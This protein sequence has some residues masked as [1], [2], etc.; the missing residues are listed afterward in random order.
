[1]S[2]PPEKMSI[3]LASRIIPNRTQKISTQPPKNCQPL[4]KKCHLYRKNLTPPDST[5]SPENFSFP[6]PPKISQLPPENFSNPQKISQPAPPKKNFSTPPP[7]IS[8]PL[9]KF[10]NPPT[11]ISQL[12]D[13]FNPP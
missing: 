7:K 2:T 6:P 12:L 9:R 8:Q 3:H 10:V 13:N 1:M 5:H 4:P 11:K